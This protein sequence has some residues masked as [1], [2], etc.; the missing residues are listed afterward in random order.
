[1]QK[2]TIHACDKKV[3]SQG[4]INDLNAIQIFSVA[5]LRREQDLD[6]KAFNVYFDVFFLESSL[7]KSG[8]VEDVVKTLIDSGKTYEKE[9]ALWLKTTDYGDEKDRVMKKSNGEYTYFVPDIAYHKN[10]WKRGFTRCIGEFGSDHHNT[11]HR[12]KI[13]L[14]ALKLGIPKNWP[15]TILHQMVT[16]LRGN[17]EVKL[18]KRAGA[19]VTLK[20]IIHE[21]GNDATRYFLAARR[22]ESQ[23]N[24]DLEL[25]INQS[26]DNPVYYIQY[27]HARICSVFKEIAEKSLDISQ[28]NGLNHLSLLNNEY[29][30]SIIDRLSKYH[31]LIQ[32]A[33]DSL[34]IHL[35]PHYLR[36][37][38]NDF[39][40]YYNAKK[41]IVKDTNLRDA[42]LCLI[43]AT[44]QVIAN[45]LRL[46][47]IH[48][49]EKM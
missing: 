25:A 44:K 35:L 38:A 12:V 31:N 17:V 36:D 37:L 11:V 21:V 3:T 8:A 13:G 23:L 1:M 15:E 42:R 46:L 2:E 6:L 26:K 49:P 19:Y 32:K 27:A 45:G 47:A 9:G 28:T 30:K 7:Y 5:Y 39:H 22:S 43:L 10:K 40:T 48:A 4:D 16:V 14:D 20:D 41:F 18:G 34:E 33:A 29:E 24:F